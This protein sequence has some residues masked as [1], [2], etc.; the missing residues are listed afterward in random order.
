MAKSQ[1]KSKQAAGHKVLLR[2]KRARHEYAIEETLE[3]GISLLGSEVKSLRAGRAE[4]G[5]AYAAITDG[6][7]FL[8]QMQISEY[9]FANQFGHA[10]KRVRKLLLHR[11]EIERLDEKVSRAGYTLLPLEVYL[12]GGR[13]KVLLGLGKGKKQYDKREDEKAREAK[14]DMARHR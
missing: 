7:A 2:N 8:Q 3:A 14:L 1:D 4:I 9:T 6:E 11:K 13:I 12:K 5:D 10:P